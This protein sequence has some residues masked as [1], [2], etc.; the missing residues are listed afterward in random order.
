MASWSGP[1]GRLAVRQTISRSV[2]GAS[3]LDDGAGE[4]RGLQGLGD[5]PPRRVGSVVGDV[6]GLVVAA[7]AAAGL[8]QRDAVGRMAVLALVRGCQGHL[9]R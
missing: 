6:A 7:G 4:A 5:Q 8:H 3:S 9:Q 1:A 2:P